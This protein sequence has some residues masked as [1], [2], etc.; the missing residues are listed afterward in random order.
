MDQDPL[1]YRYYVLE[2]RLYSPTNLLKK[3]NNYSVGSCTLRDNMVSKRI[4]LITRSD[5]VSIQNITADVTL[6]A[7]AAIFPILFPF[8]K[9]Y[10][11]GACYLADYL[12]LRMRGHFTLFTL[13][14]P[15]LLVM[16][17]IRQANVL[18][19]A[20]PQVVLNEELDYWR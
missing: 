6:T 13:F 8:S 5:G 15:Y 3:E 19:N 20:V 10:F 17:V 16:F 14:K 2:D 1:V 4:E 9:G 7:E 12:H 18:A 11:V